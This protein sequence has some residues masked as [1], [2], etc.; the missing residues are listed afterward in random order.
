MRQHIRHLRNRKN[1]TESPTR[2]L[3]QASK[4]WKKVTESIIEL[5]SIKF[6]S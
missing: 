1:M 4:N 2:I 6:I 5:F 3:L